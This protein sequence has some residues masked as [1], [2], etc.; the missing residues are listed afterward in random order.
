MSKPTDSV[1][2]SLRMT[3]PAPE[4]WLVGAVLILF[5]VA[6]TAAIP[7]ISAAIRGALAGAEN[8][9]QSAERADRLVSVRLRFVSVRLVE[10]T[11]PD[12]G[13]SAS[14]ECPAEFNADHIEFARPSDLAAQIRLHGFNARAPPVLIA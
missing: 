10:P 1:T 9:A 5:G 4:S 11:A 2:A 13:N 3:R 8:A 6:V 12:V 14:L 7:P